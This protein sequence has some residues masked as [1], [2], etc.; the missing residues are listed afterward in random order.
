[1]TVP[2][3]IQYARVSSAR[4]SCRFSAFCSARIPAEAC[5]TVLMQLRLLLADDGLLRA[6]LREVALGRAQPELEVAL[7]AQPA[8]GAEA[9]DGEVVLLLHGCLEA[10]H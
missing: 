4:I 6:P 8:P 3:S 2:T 10:A 1:M 5:L 9:G 7:E